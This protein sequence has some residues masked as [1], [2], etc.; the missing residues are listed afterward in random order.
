MWFHSRII[1]FLFLAPF[2][3]SFIWFVFFDYASIWH[4]VFTMLFTGFVFFLI[5]LFLKK[6]DKSFPIKKKEEKASN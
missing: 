1:D 5:F 3:I 2:F 4:F 6:I